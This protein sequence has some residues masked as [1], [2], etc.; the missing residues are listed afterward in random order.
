[1]V[2]EVTVDGED[3][4]LALQHLDVGGEMWGTGH[5]KLGCSPAVGGESADLLEAE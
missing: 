4:A 5:R 2:S 1:M 3:G